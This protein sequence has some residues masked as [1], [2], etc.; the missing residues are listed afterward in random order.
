MWQRWSVF[1]SLFFS[2]FLFD[3]VFVTREEIRAC[4][5]V[6]RVLEKVIAHVL[7]FLYASYVKSINIM[8]KKKKLTVFN[9]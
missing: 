5:I 7:H 2:S 8:L 1:P 4:V 9:R 3:N 6:G